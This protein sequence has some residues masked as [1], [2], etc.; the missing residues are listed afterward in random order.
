[1]KIKVNGEEQAV[2]GSSI[3]IAQL[4]KLN[5]V[6]NPGMVTVQLDGEF[7][8]KDNYEA[9]QVKENNEVEFLYYMGGG[10]V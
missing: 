3:S 1:M 6:E 9:T 2:E 7:V 10:S 5:E 8:D 4:L